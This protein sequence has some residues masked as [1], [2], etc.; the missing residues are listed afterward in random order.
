MRPRP[1]GFFDPL[2]YD[3]M[4][5]KSRIW[6]VLVLGLGVALLAAAI[7]A[8]SFLNFSPRLPLDAQRTTWT[9]H[10]DS[11]RALVVGGGE[12]N[13]DA[14]ASDKPAEPH[15]PEGPDSPDEQGAPEEAEAPEDAEAPAESKDAGE[16]DALADEGSDAVPGN[17]P[18]GEQPEG[19]QPEGEQPAADKPEGDKPEG[20]KPDGDKPAAPKGPEIYEGPLTYQLHMNIGEQ[21]D[22]KTAQVRVGE[23]TVRGDDPSAKQDVKNLYS[24]RVWSYVIDRE[25]GEAEE[26]AKLTH[27]IAM[28]ESEVDVGGYWLKFPAHAEKTNYP[29]FDP[30]LRQAREAVF[31][32]ET[33]IEG[34]TVYRYHQEFEPENVAKLYAGMLNTTS[35]PTPEGGSEQGFLFHGASNDFFVDQ[36]TGMLV[37]M[38]VDIDDYYGTGDGERAYD[39]LQFAGSTSEEDRAAF[40][41]QAADIPDQTAA[42]IARWAVGGLGGL[43]TLL[44]LLGALGAFGRRG[45]NSSGRKG[46]D[47]AAGHGG[48]TGNARSVGNARPVRR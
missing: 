8:G 40:L 7:S 4:L 28:P 20:D 42:R 14:D 38:D 18:E 12:E 15:S 21:S 6:S 36:E 43:L 45:G 48:R 24:A 22:A 11:G 10:D 19:E 2:D 9:L 39:A 23:T 25:T 30:T 1:A 33:E 16:H 46:Q 5:P 35:L 17:A 29:V 34:R 37:G 3:P 31:A 41:E 13:A 44:G 27:T 47:R 26:P 32:E